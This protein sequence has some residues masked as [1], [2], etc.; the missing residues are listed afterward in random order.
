MT[1]LPV[2]LFR[3]NNRYNLQDVNFLKCNPMV[4][5]P[6]KEHVRKNNL[7]VRK[8]HINLIKR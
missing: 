6:S 8:N 2:I 5:Y 4:K 3:N 7:V 1:S